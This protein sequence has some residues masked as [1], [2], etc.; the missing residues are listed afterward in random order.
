MIPS[1]TRYFGLRMANYPLNL[2]VAGYWTKEEL[3]NRLLQNNFPFEPAIVKFLLFIAALLPTEKNVESHGETSSEWRQLQ[4]VNAARMFCGLIH[5]HAAS[6]RS[7]QVL[8]GHGVEIA[9]EDLKRLDSNFFSAIGGAHSL[10]FAPAVHDL[11][12]ATNKRVDQLITPLAIAHYFDCLGWTHHFASCDEPAGFRD[13]QFPNR[14]ELPDDYATTIKQLATLRCAYKAVQKNVFGLDHNFSYRSVRTPPIGY[15]PRSTARPSTNDTVRNRLREAPDTVM[16]LYHILTLQPM[17]LDD[18]SMPG[19]FAQL[20]KGT[21]HNRFIP[22]GMA[23]TKRNLLPILERD[24][25]IIPKWLDL[26]GPSASDNRVMR[27]PMTPAEIRDLCNT[28]GII[29]RGRPPKR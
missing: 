3:F 1:R 25:S 20:L 5:F 18:W 15:A 29:K 4:L 8:A 27:P 14:N 26:V 28:L 12:T 19:V 21:K 7:K 24:N 10:V 16:I 11:L 13:L 6:P 2:G 23:A 22:L 9:K 17:L